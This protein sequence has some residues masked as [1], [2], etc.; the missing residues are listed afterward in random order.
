M[1]HIVPACLL[2]AVVLGQIPVEVVVETDRVLGVINHLEP[3]SSRHCVV[4]PRRHVPRLHD[5]DDQEL[6]Q[7]ASAI[8][9]IAR[10]FELNDFNVLLNNGELAGQTVFHV[11]FHVIPKWGAEDGLQM[12]RDAAV[13]A[14]EV[15]G[16]EA[17]PRIAPL[18]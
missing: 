11:H 2:C 7:M 10:D 14:E 8:R 5:V 9:E 17:S 15:P 13:H 3:L 12:S 18:G 16:G 6:A 4:F 1:P